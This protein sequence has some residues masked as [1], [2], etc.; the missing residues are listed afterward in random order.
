MTSHL[1]TPAFEQNSTS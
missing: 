1:Q